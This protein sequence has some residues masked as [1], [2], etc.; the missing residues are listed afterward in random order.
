MNK[1]CIPIGRY[2]RK[3]YTTIHGRRTLH[4]IIAHRRVVSKVDRFRPIQAEGL[5]HYILWLRLK[6]TVIIEA[7]RLSHLESTNTSL[8]NGVYR[9]I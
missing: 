3:V 6:T 7:K 5:D 8:H 9:T 1:K 4:G 2:A